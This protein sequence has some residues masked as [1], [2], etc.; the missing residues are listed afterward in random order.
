MWNLLQVLAKDHDIQVLSLYESFHEGAKNLAPVTSGLLRV[1]RPHHAPRM[2][3]RRINELDPDVLYLPWSA[4]IFLGKSNRRIP[5]ILDFVGPGLMERF[6]EEGHVPAHL[7]RL[8]LD[9]FWFGDL[10]V[11][12]TERERHYLL[13]LLAASG[14]LSMGDF[15]QNDP[16]IHVARMTPPQDPPSPRLE[17]SS[18]P[19]ILLL[20][21]AFLPWYDH[22]MLASALERL[23]PKARESLRILVLGGNPRMPE[24]ER[25]VR[26]ALAG[27]AGR[28]V[29][30][31]LGIVPFAKRVGAYLRADVGLSVAPATVEDELSSRTRIVD[32]LWAR[33]PV[34]ASGRDEYSEM[35][36]EAGAGFRYE[37]N[38]ASLAGVIQDLLDDPGA[39]ARAR[40]QIEPLLAGPFHPSIANSA[41]V[42]FLENPYVT[43]RKAIGG[44]ATRSAAVWVRDV[45]KVL[46]SGRT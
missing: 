16:L 27:E 28:D 12:T 46:R 32:Y 17:R 38:G 10:F 45:V 35:I 40:A 13:G 22:G 2:I 29:L 3:A 20:A 8:Q 14:R 42:R 39:I 37:P 1:E 26:R 24:S 44:G 30:E 34:I 21:G 43:D 19:L 41:I 31:F 5:T 23:D 7:L 15:R 18:R 36:L 25:A 4:T 6:V 33:L 11:T 9:S